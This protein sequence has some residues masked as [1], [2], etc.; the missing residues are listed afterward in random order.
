MFMFLP[1]LIALC[2]AFSTI[3]SKRKYS[4]FLW[5]GLLIVTLFWFKHHASSI[6]TLSF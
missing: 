5:L 3:A 6:L 4:Y 2:A 1:F